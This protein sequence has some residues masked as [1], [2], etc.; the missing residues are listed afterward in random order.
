MKNLQCADRVKI[1]T[2]SQSEMGW[3]YIDLADTTI[4]TTYG[5]SA[6]LN[7]SCQVT[8]EVPY[9]MAITVMDGTPWN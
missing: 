5:W 8:I 4:N 3:Y 7:A 2:V 9:V 6:A 1:L